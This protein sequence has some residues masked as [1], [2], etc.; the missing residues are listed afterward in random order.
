[1][2]VQSHV[3]HERLLQILT[4][5]EP[6]G[7]EHIGNAPTKALDHPVGSGRAWPGQA[8]F[9]AQG[10]TQLVKLMVARGLAL[11]AGK[12]SVGELLAVVGQDL[13]HPDRTSLVQGVQKGASGSG[14]LVAIDLNE[15]PA[16]G[17]FNGHEQI[18][19]AGLVR[20][21]G[22]VFDIDVDEPWLVA[23]E[24]FVGLRGFFGLE[25]VEVANAIAAK[26]PIKTR[27]CGLGAKK[28]AGDSQQVVQGQKQGLAKFDHDLF[29][30]R[31]E[32]G[33]KPV[34]SVQSV[35][36][37]VS[38]LPLVNG[39]FTHAITLRQSCS[40]LRARR[41]LRSNGG[42]GACVL[43]Q[44][45][46]HDKAPG[47]TAVVTQRL[48]TSCLMTSLAMNSGYRFES[49]QSSGMR[50]VDIDQCG[51]AHKTP[52]HSTAGTVQHSYLIAVHHGQIA[53]QLWS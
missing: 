41:H 24:G 13:L 39:A 46:H 15:H 16:R 14:R 9:N 31:C 32:R 7:F 26:T 44:G 20:H 52:L 53:Q 27:A 11:T 3:T 42:R 25:G 47:C 33:L 23:F 21:L 49:M 17:A 36:K 37:A 22:Q 30:C 12:Q 18:A 8:V 35:M 6:V 43:V 4:T 40:S 50:H 2:V 29:L 45:N 10:L 48:S 19:P 38:G 1:M 51:E 28:F 34:R 5:G